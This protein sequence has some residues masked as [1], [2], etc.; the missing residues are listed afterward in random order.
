M[1]TPFPV[2]F[3]GSTA[4]VRRQRVEGTTKGARSRTVSLD[5]ETV[6]V[7]H[8]HHRQQAEERLAAGSAWNDTSGLVFTSRWG[9][10]LYPDTVTALM[11]KLI[12]RHNK[13]GTP[14]AELLPHDRLHD[15]RHLHATTLQVSGVA[16]AASFGSI[17]ERD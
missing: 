16:S 14:P 11:T 1:A 17:R 12:N 5:R 8:D 4:V 6:A 9:E 15:L 7:L 3:S 13:A 10:P 2:T